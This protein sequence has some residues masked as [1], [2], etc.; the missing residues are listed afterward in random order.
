MKQTIKEVK[1]VL[2]NVDVELGSS[3]ILS[4]RF[5]PKLLNSVLCCQGVH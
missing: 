2:K 1:K 5:C 3:G 4:A